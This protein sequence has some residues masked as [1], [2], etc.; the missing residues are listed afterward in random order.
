MA[1]FDNLTEIVLFLV[2]SALYFGDWY[3]PTVSAWSD[4]HLFK[5][6]HRA[7]CRYMWLPHHLFFP[8]FVSPPI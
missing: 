1:L 4:Y 6:W 7:A 5:K 2:L 8:S 3:A